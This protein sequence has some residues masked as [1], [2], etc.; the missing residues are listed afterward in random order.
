MLR[1]DDE[2]RDTMGGGTLSKALYGAVLWCCVSMAAAACKRER[3]P[4]GPG[5]TAAAKSPQAAKKGLAAGWP[6]LSRALRAVIEDC[7]VT[8][9]GVARNCR[10]DADQE[11][12]KQEQTAGVRQSLM[13]YCQAQEDDNFLIRA[14]ALGRLNRL[15]FYQT[16]REEGDASVLRCLM[17]VLEG[18]TQ[19]EHARTLVRAAAF[20][21]TALRREEPI[22]RFIAAAHPLEVRVAGY[23]SLWANGRLRLLD[24]LV[25]RLENRREPPVRQAI[26]RGF[27]YGGRLEEQ[28]KDKVCAVLDRFLG[29]EEVA[30]AGT[31]V[32]T[33]ATACPEQG[34]RILAAA[35]ASLARGK[36][37]VGHVRA[38][39]GLNGAES[40]RA[41]AVQ[42]KKSVAFLAGVVE[43]MKVK[44]T[45]RALGLR[46]L[47]EL[48]RKAALPLARKHQEDASLWVRES[49]E[50]ILER[51]SSRR[52]RH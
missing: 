22:L 23:E 37:D 15:A 28:E 51:K 47:A 24:Y 19:R 11:L 9:Y 35:E 14:L 25:R 36:L 50:A 33:A 49:A 6:A 16:L 4:A 29:D 30:V 41:S 5:R 48:D 26:L 39:H 52:G 12:A 46:Y 7:D 43:S 8:D 3:G 20:V 13:T 1:A 38:I 32:S 17:R 40:P 10:S 34:D 45:T 2:S 18:A 27:D 42:R 21:A 31:A 44:D